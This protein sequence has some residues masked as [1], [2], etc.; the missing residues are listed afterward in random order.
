VVL[1][2]TTPLWI[3]LAAPLLL[4]EKTPRSTWLGIVVAMAGGILIGLADWS[5]AQR[6]LAAWGDVLALLGAIFGAGYLL[7][8]RHI[9]ARLSFAAYVWFVYGV[10]A[11]VLTGWALMSGLRLTG[12]TP[13]AVVYMIALGLVPQLIGHSSANYALRDL[14]ASMVG[15]VVLGEPVGSTLLAILLLREW[16]VQLQVVGGLVVLAGIAVATLAR[17]SAAPIQGSLEPSEP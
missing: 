3:G 14:P 11:L 16:P 9:R 5:E 7:I 2:T 15:V 17:Q 6:D 10:A 4:G 1:V 12:Y 13:T 8:G